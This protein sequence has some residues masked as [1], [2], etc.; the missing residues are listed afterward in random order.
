MDVRFTISRTLKASLLTTTPIRP[1]H[2]PDYVRCNAVTTQI[3]RVK[4]EHPN[5]E[6]EVMAGDVASAFRNISIHS[7]S[8]FLFAGRI[9]EENAIVI[10]LSAPFGW[11]RSP[12]FYEILGGAISHV[13]GSQDN[14]VNTTGFLNYHWVDDQI[15]VAQI[16]NM[17]RSLRFAIAAILGAEAI[18]DEKFTL[19][20][21]QQRVFRLEFDW[22]A[23][24]ITNAKALPI[25]Y[26][27]LTARRHLHSCCSAF[28]P[29]T[30]VDYFNTLPPPNIVVDVNASDFGLCVLDVSER[31]ALTYQFSPAETALIFDFKSDSSNGYD[32]IFRELLLQHIRPGAKQA[33]IAKSEGSS[34]HTSSQLLRFSASH[35]SGANNSRADAGSCLSASP[36]FET[37]FASLTSGWTQATPN[38][39]VQGLIDIWQGIS[40]LTPLPTPPSSSTNGR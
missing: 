40:A 1:H 31:F 11:T 15:N 27:E 2:K 39:D 16:S 14:A 18:N 4:R 21:I 6:I 25:P 37:L 8:G 38:L 33:L 28:S 22:V 23:E 13:H 7:N 24:T 26:G 20:K 17:N 35:V 10:E 3:L 5:A 29:T 32:I 12:G 34:D 9:E 36:S 30:T 19:W